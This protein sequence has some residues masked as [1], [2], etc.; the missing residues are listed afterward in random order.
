MGNLY[1][2]LRMIGIACIAFVLSSVVTGYLI[3]LA[4][5]RFFPICS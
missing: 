5:Q 4:A 2:L 3:Y 1:P